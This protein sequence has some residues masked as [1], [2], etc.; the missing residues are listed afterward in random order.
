MLATVS[1]VLQ[2]R[3]VLLVDDN[4]TNR[5]VLMGQLLQCGVDPVSAG[6][7]GEAVLLMRHAAAARRPFEAALLDHQ[8]PD[9]DGAELGRI[10]AGDDTLA[11]TRLIF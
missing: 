3:R 11:S 9:C 7:A 6:S 10:I 2:G 4:T 1:E 5:T 8:M